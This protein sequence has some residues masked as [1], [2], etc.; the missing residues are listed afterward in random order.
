MRSTLITRPRKDAAPLA[1]LLRAAGYQPVLFPTID[2]RPVEDNPAWQRALAKWDCYDWVVFTSA[3]TVEALPRSPLG[4]GAGGGGKIAVIGTKTAAALRARGLEPDVVPDEHTAEALLPLLGDLRGRWV[5]FPSA[6]IARETLPA[7]V[8][9][10]GGV[11]HQVTVYR[12]LPAA[13]DPDG[14]QALRQGVAWLT[15][16]SPSTVENFVVLVW[17][18]GLDPLDLPGAPRVACI[19]P[20]TADAARQHGFR[21]DATAEPHTIEGLV[22]AIRAADNERQPNRP[23]RLTD[24]SDQLTN[25]T[26]Q[27]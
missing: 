20:V 25:Q 24:Q 27:P 2:I 9:A 15:F 10:A 1:E 17:Q 14:L 21:V 23:I 12:T 13:P 6:D 16:T 22:A 3:N 7:G 18:A 8:L 19:G 26:N 5:L 11:V 4:G